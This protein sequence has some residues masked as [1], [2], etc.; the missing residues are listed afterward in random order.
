M[1]RKEEHP[2]NPQIRLALIGLT[3]LNGIPA[4]PALA[5]V[6]R[7]HPVRTR[8]Y[9]YG[10][11]YWIPA[12]A[13]MTGFQKPNCVTIPIQTMTLRLS[14]SRGCGDRFRALAVT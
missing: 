11:E 4:T 5:G 3:Q 1:L 12:F 8:K 2:Q 7:L 13:R 6:Q 9:A 10:F 14:C